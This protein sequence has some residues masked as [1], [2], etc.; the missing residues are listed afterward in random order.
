M[1]RSVG[2]H[3]TDNLERELEAAVGEAFARALTRHS[4]IALAV[5]GGIDSMVLLELAAKVV[6]ADRLIVATFDHG[7]GRAAS[8][9]AALVR[10]RAAALG[11]ICVAGRRPSA[12]ER[13]HCSEAALRE[14]R[15]EFLRTVAGEWSAAVATAHS[16][17][18]QL[19]TVLMRVL[20]GAGARGLAGLY[21]T[22]P[23][24]R[25]LL[26]FTRTQ[27]AA[28]AASSGVRWREDPSNASRRYLRNR[29]RHDLLP[30]L[31][32]VNPRIAS[33]L[34]E[35]AARAYEWRRSVEELASPLVAAASADGVDVDAAA[36][37]RLDRAGVGVLWPALAARAGVALDRRGTHRLVKF[38]ANARVGSRVQVAGGWQVVRSRDAFQLR[39]SA[40]NTPTPAD[41]GPAAEV[42]WGRWLFR[43]VSSEQAAGRGT[44]NGWSIRLPSAS[45]AKIRAWQ[46]GDALVVR[47][48]GTPRK[49]KRL[50]SSAGVT[51]H[52]RA[53][54]PVVLVENEIVW[55]P[56]V[57]RAG[58]A[59]VSET[60]HS[61]AR[62]ADSGLTFV[63]EQLSR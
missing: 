44:N 50:L 51:G 13:A 43:R 22:S 1:G 36:L 27:I 10:R 48:G 26:G 18:D 35:I 17:D 21:A 52:D 7:T 60:R 32:A 49:V 55:I 3:R 28:H 45:A 23:T 14:A 24:V 30:A 6:S 20:R 63:C 54:W 8:A 53:G 42:R 59:A 58:G 15:W 11:V 4:R 5:S 2:S 61:G 29:V 39:P 19:E 16:R 9:A 34:L 56:G 46:P 37:G 41:L 40:A 62:T 12:G 31:V 25:P 38:T 47:A 33:D 57:M